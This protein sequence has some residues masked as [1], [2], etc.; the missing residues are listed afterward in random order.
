MRASCD[1]SDHSDRVSLHH[2]VRHSNALED[3]R[4][5][6][7]VHHH[8]TPSVWALRV[9]VQQSDELLEQSEVRGQ[10]EEERLDRHE[11][12][13]HELLQGVWLVLVQRIAL[14]NQIKRPDVNLHLL[15]DFEDVSDEEV[16]ECGHESGF[17]EH[18]PLF[19]ESVVEDPESLSGEERTYFDGDGWVGVVEDLEHSLDEVVEIEF[20]K[21][22]VV[23]GET[24]QHVQHLGLSE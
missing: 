20:L 2:L 15:W 4:Q 6:P 14:R 12:L 19:G 16:V 23:S 8:L 5:N 3:L 11:S 10:I 22:L 1:V 18:L 13:G 17:A 24:N 9:H 7:I 21:E